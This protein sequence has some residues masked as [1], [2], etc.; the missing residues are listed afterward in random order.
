[1]KFISCILF[2]IIF[3][4]QN[5]FAQNSTE[6]TK[7]NASDVFNP[8]TNYYPS[9]IYRSAS[10]M[11]GPNY[12]QN[13]ADYTIT[14]ALNSD[15]SM[16]SGK[17]RIEYTNNSPDALD[18]IWLQLDQNKFNSESRGNKTTPP[19][20]GR[21]GVKNFKGGYEISNVR[22]EKITK[23]TKI[24]NV[25]D[26]FLVEDT[27][28]QL[29]LKENLNSGE[30]L[31]ISMDF[32]FKI[33]NNGS[34]RM[35]KFSA[36][37]G[38]VFQL[39]QWY[40]RVCV[41]D[42]ITGWNTNPYLGGGEFYLEYGDIDFEIVV[43]SNHIV[44]AS[45]QLQNPKS[46]LNASQLKNLEKAYNSEK[47]IEIHSPKEPEK[48][49]KEVSSTK[50]WKF[51]CENTRDVA[52]ASSEAFVWDAAFAKLPSGKKCLVQSVYPIEY[53]GKLAWGRSTEY[54]KHSIEYYS[55]TLMEYPY[56]VATNVAGIVSGMEYPGIVFC[57]A[58]DT[59]GDLFG[60]TDHEFGHTWFPMIVGSNERKY[61]WMDEG[62][63]TYFNEL[64]LKEFNKGEFY[65]EQFADQRAGIF[66]KNK[67]ILNYADAIS[68]SDLG[69]LAYFKPAMGLEML[70]EA[71][72]GED[73]FNYA[74]KQYIKRWAFKHPSPFDFFHTIENAS[75][76]D[77]GWFWKSWF[78]EKYKID[79]AIK[80]V[81]YKNN[82][83]EEGIT[84]RL[85]NMEQMPMPVE[86]EIKEISG[87]IYEVNLPVEIWQKSGE[88]IF[89]YP[90][91]Q[92]IEYVKLNP[93]RILPDINLRNNIWKTNNR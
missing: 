78:F 5:N 63:N 31:S 83:P 28:M 25:L 47:T 48:D 32:N 21:Y 79:Q 35:G 92:P 12:W 55:K 8:L 86:L 39:A 46:V 73:R 90:S 20:V 19:F 85:E 75:G 26:K 36:K 17:V 60:V 68:E 51:R 42:D 14:C 37:N 76:E 65:Q 93:R 81:N 9:T 80:S 69:I 71:V 27:R 23:K 3:S 91:K 49:F 57:G 41:Y 18:F 30:K 67:S 66:Y 62:F 34:D 82:T 53:G 50:I 64:S 16:I 29:R 43:P 74:F 89:D 6:V 70:K 2:L 56:P 54:A 22:V 10:G 72:I 4:F 77:L 11:P 13:K 61:A 59:Q 40:P 52:W 58:S 24:L 44:V 15:E 88:W 7:Y 1:M 38:T 45:G 84:I 33:P 87:K